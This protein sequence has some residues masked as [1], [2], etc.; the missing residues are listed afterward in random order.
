MVSVICKI[1][2]TLSLLCLAFFGG[3]LCYRIARAD[4]AK[5][6]KQT[7]LYECL[8]KKLQEDC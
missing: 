1:I 3:Y 7:E 5:E 6:E 2:L 8:L 4:I